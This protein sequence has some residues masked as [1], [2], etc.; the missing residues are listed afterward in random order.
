MN[1]EQQLEALL[2]YLA[3]TRGFDFTG[4]K[5]ASLQRRVTKRMQEVGIEGFT[6][7]LDYLE[8][9]PDEFESL[10]NT[11]L[12]NVTGVFRDR[13]ARERLAHPGS[14]APRD[15]RTRCGCGAQ[16]ARPERRPTASQSRSP[17]HWARRTSRRG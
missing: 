1:Q 11:I 9:H 2:E 3:R 6:E 16:G 8:V 17:R 14:W 12:I 4:Y 7:Y 5:R 13:D 15:P 10:F